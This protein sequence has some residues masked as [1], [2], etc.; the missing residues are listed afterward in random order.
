MSTHKNDAI[1]R[2]ERWREQNH[3]ERNTCACQLPQHDIMNQKLVYVAKYLPK[4]F[5][6]SFCKS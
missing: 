5:M 4:Y 1:Y 3:E 6:L 2:A